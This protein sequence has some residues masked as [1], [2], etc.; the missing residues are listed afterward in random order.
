MT[1]RQ[2]KWFTSYHNTLDRQ[3]HM[4]DGLLEYKCQGVR[5]NKSSIPQEPSAQPLDAVAP[6]S[7]KDMNE[8]TKTEC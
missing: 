2:R 7:S 1:N 4:C 5:L 6:T 8:I 3:R